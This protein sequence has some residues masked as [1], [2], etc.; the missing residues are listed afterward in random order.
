METFQV[1]VFLCKSAK[2]P[3]APVMSLP[4]LRLP[5]EELYENLSQRTL[6]LLEVKVKSSKEDLSLL[7]N[8]EVENFGF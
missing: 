2:C 5:N 1:S 8:L 4:L 7:V 6:K 3:C